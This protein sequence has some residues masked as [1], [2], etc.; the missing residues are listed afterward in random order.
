MKKKLLATLALTLTLALCLLPAT[1]LAAEYNMTN[2][3]V[4]VTREADGKQYVQ[5]GTGDAVEDEAPVLTGYTNRNVIK[6]ISVDGSGT[7]NVTLSGLEMFGK[8]PLIEIGDDE[9]V[10]NAVINLE[11]Q[12]QLTNNDPG[13]QTS[14]IHI[15]TGS[16]TITAKDND[17]ENKLK[18]LNTC[19]GAAIGSNVYEECKANI[20]ITGNAYVN[21]FSAAGACIGG[22]DQ[23]GFAG[24][25]VIDGNAKLEGLNN[26]V[27]N[28]I[29]VLGCGIGG[30][31]TGSIEI[32]DNAEVVLLN[33]DATLGQS[34][35]GTSTEANGS[36]TLDGSATI[37]V[38][39]EL[40]LGG[41]E[42]VPGVQVKIG[43]GVQFIDR[44]GS[45][46]DRDSGCIII[47]GT[48]IEEP[49]ESAQTYYAQDEAFRVVDKDGNTV[50]YE[51]TLE[52]GVLTIT[53]PKGAKLTGA[54]EDMQL[55]STKGATE[56]RFGTSVLPIAEL[57]HGVGMQGDTVVLTKNGKLTNGGADY[58]E[59]LK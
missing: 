46:I 17:D 30:V 58:S 7:I 35:S 26:G 44:D 54:L 1:A 43:D 23:G 12:N 48:L 29:A 53:A 2:G 4:T 40:Y 28:Y 52:D 25:I 57:Y 49:V 38:L 16:L 8:G 20:T 10:T 59:L 22:G 9:H 56:L 34:Y 39:D 19:N 27:E 18:V 11:G 32:K 55:L 21:T 51:M 13:L 14:A 45:P 47:N 50:P 5:Q 6:L 36:I 37:R 31:Y 42:S 15:K 3:S 41:S 24:R 33:W